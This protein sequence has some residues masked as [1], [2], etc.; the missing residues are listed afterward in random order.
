[1]CACVVEDIDFGLGKGDRAV[2]IT[3]LSHAEEVVGERVHD[4]AIISAWWKLWE[5]HLGFWLCRWFVAICVYTR[6]F[7]VIFITR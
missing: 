4:E 6:F 5:W 2:G 1:V 3:E 7:L